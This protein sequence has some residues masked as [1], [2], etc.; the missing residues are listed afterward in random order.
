MK[1]ISIIILVCFSVITSKAQLAPGEYT[2]KNK[3]AIAS[4]ESAL[5]YFNSHNDTKAQE[6][7]TKAIE[8]M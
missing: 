5:N 4:F 7:L 8:K 6:E 1:K 3:K 2:T